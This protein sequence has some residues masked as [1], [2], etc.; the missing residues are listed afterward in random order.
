[1]GTEAKPLITKIH[2]RYYDVG[3]FDHPGGCSALECARDRDATELFESYHALF[4]ARPLKTLARYEV[5]REQAEGA[6][7]FLGEKRFGPSEVDWPATLE[8]GFRADIM[9]CARRYFQTEQRRR[10]LPTLAAATKAPPRRWIE[11]AVL[12]AVFF[13]AL[14]PFVR[15]NWLALFVTPVLGWFFL[16]N[17][18]HDALHFAM[19]RH[20]GVNA[21]MPY[22]FPWFMSPKLWMHQHVI[23]HHVFPNDPDRDPDVRAAPDI[24][25]QNPGSAW[26]P[27][28]VKQGRVTTLLALYSLISLMRNLLRDHLTRLSGWFNDTVPL[29]FS[30]RRRRYLHIAGRLLVASSLFVWPFF[31]FPFWKALA[32][33]T[34]P[35]MLLSELFGLF[36]QVNHVTDE[37]VEAAQRR[38]S[39][40][41]ESQVQTACSYATG[42]YLAFLA[43]GGLNLQIEHHLLPGVNHHHLFRLSPEIQR[44]CAKHGV[45]Y[46]SYPSWWAA[47]RAHFA[48]MRRLALQPAATPQVEETQAG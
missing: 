11:I 12:G 35:S 16:V 43:S 40:W 33:A 46:H 6:D 45:P 2:G 14:V 48:C 24:L 13:A 28:H 3:S 10:R 4:R 44:I 25:R 38:S 36:S 32:F 20:P 9:E 1:M 22:V 19:S 31:A 41:Y 42:S 30:T 29:V 34:V 7:R 39:N 47:L 8:S 23:G 18:W 26:C 17:F 5:P 15:G 21:L 27:A 37:N